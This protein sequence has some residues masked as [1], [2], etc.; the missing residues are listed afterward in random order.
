MLPRYGGDA[1]SYTI[2]WRQGT[3]QNPGAPSMWRAATNTTFTRVFLPIRNTSTEC[4]CQQL[5]G[6]ER[7]VARIPAQFGQLVEAAEQTN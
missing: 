4:E 2:E 5:G 7:M 3:S 6:S 1:T